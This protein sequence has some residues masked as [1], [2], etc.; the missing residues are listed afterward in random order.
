MS[1]GLGFV[2]KDSHNRTARNYPTLEA[3]RRAVRSDVP[4]GARW[5]IRRLL[6]DGTVSALVT[7]GRKTG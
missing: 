2:V 5:E 6:K 1:E 4:V 7:S 3:A